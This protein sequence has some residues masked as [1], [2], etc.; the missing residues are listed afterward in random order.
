MSILSE[1]KP[2]FLFLGKFII[3][4]LVLTCIYM[5]YLSQY[6]EAAFETD[7]IT[8]AVAK[9]SSALVRFLGEESHLAPHPNQ[10]ADKFFVNNKYVAR[11]VEGCNAISVMILFAAFIVSF[12]TT[13]K[14]TTLY[15]L[16]G[17]VIIYLL[18]IMRI[19]LI[20]LGA[21]YYPEY[22][23]FIHDIIFPLFIY[24]VVFVLWIIWVLKFYKNAKQAKA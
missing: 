16:A 5:L 1:N 10:A 13:V 2:F 6:N 14:R 17:F 15:I 23:S 3:S 9:Q 21:Y 24:G 4:Y 12:S 7:G 22:S 8:H 11:I 18:N 20:T 19:A